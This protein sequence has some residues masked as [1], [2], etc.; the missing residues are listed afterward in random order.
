M[1]KNNIIFYSLIGISFILGLADYALSMFLLST[2]Y[3][4]EIN[5]IAY[6]YFLLIP[7]LLL[8]PKEDKFFN[9]VFSCL[10]ALLG[11]VVLINVINLIGY[12]QV[13]S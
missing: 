4:V 1:K 2:G 8:F 7:F 13:I 10:V 12:L 9:C 5:A 3:F 11:A 6:P